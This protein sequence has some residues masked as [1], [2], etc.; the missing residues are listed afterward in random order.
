MV[1]EGRAMATAAAA[2]EPAIAAQVAELRDCADVDFKPLGLASTLDSARASAILRAW[3][4]ADA[5]LLLRLVLA[6]R[7]MYVQHQRRLVEAVTDPRVKFEISTV[8]ELDGVEMC[9]I[10]STG[11]GGGEV[12]FA[13][14]LHEVN[15]G[16]LLAATSAA[17]PKYSQPRLTLQVK[18]LLH[19]LAPPQINLLGPALISE[20]LNV[21]DLSL[22]AWTLDMQ[23][24]E[25]NASVEVRRSFIAALPRVFGR[26]LETD[27]I[28]ISLPT[29]FPKL[30]PALT[31]QS[32][33]HF[34]SS[35]KPI[36]KLYDDLPWSPRWDVQEMVRRTWSFIVEE[37][38]LFKKLCTDSLAARR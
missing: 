2:L 26:P 6:L 10:G 33:Q 11:E 18:F 23:V 17:V 32:S 7:A 1:A 34:D 31:L 37:N 8:G 30:P 35:G 13:A 3:T 15:L 9:L 4:A 28:H 29:Q 27:T 5:S 21:A 16:P 19:S 20:A 38:V 22:P 14:P 24:Q 36:T 25:A 12:Q